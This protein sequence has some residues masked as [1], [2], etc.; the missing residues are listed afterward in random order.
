M[1]RY[2]LPIVAVAVTLVLVTLVEW[3][4]GFPPLIFLI[5]PIAL[6]F[7]FAGRG[8]GVVALAVGRSPA[9]MY[10]SSPFASS[11]STAKDLC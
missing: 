8:P 9:T 2:S 3:A 7:I 1:A 5:A 6:T 11:R 4:L 10:L